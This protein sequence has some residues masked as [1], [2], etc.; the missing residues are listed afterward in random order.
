M[1][2]ISHAGRVR[3]FHLSGN[4]RYIPRAADSEVT[5][6]A[7][8]AAAAVH[9]SLQWAQQRTKVEEIGEDSSYFGSGGGE[10]KKRPV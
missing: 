10:R 1:S 9:C 7:S 4:P 5:V 2:K 6:V 8:I 3:N